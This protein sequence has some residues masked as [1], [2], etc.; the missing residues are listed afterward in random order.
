MEEKTVPILGIRVTDRKKEAGKV[1]KVLTNY[2]CSIKTR[3]GLHET[4]NEFCSSEGIIL[5]ELYGEQEKID[6]L[7]AELQAIEGIN[8]REM[9]L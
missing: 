8:V 6:A 2:G 1:Q 4:S 5:L 9:D 3:V 7:K